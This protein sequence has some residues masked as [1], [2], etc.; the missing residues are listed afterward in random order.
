MLLAG[1]GEGFLIDA[2]RNMSCHGRVVELVFGSVSL[3]YGTNSISRTVLYTERSSLCRREGKIK[4][5]SIRKRR[6]KTN[7]ELKL[8]QQID[9]EHNFILLMN[10]KR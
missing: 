6:T 3:E 9:R 5:R 4:E 2:D 8:K 7:Q 1:A 10:G